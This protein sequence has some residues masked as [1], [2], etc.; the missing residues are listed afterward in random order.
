MGMAVLAVLLTCLTFTACSDDDDD[1]IVVDYTKDIVGAWV[2]EEGEKFEVLVVKADGTLFS[3][4]M[5]DGEPWNNVKGTWTLEGKHITMIFEDDDNFDGTIEVIAGETL[6][7]I[8]GVSG[9]RTIYHYTDTLLP[10]QFVG[11]WTCLQ[12]NHAEALTIKSDGSIVSTGMN[13]GNYWEEAKGHINVANGFYSLAFTDTDVISAGRYEIV[14]G[15]AMV[16]HDAVNDQTLTYEYCEKDLSK[17]IVGQWV[18]LTSASET[19]GL[20]M[21]IMT[22]NEDGTT[23]YTGYDPVSS[24]SGLNGLAS[25]K[26]FGDLMVHI[27]P[28][29]YV[30]YGMPK[31][32]FMRMSYSEDGMDFGD[33]MTLSYSLLSGDKV[34]ES[35][36]SWLRVKQTL[37]L[38]EMKY[39]YKTIYLSNVKGLD[40]DIELMGQTFNFAKMDGEAL[41]SVLS[42]VDYSVEFPSANTIKYSFNVQNSPVVMECPI[43]VDGNKMTIKMSSLVPVMRDID[44][45]TFQDK[46]DTQLH[47]YMS[48]KCFIDFFGNLSLMLMAQKGEINIEDAA[49][50]EAW[51]QGVEDVVESINLSF[52]MTKSK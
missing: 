41:H 51:F 40:E 39:D 17:E 26:M 45:Y 36:I 7:L 24:M 52:V 6:A 12:P 32:T 31:Y 2:A 1:T 10:A 21:M 44:V 46:Y 34:I 50:V 13:D 22:F 33:T 16:F 37:N 20:N 8:D 38:P 49:A 29:E 5:E 15:M 43:K 3:D 19:A 9:E 18:N 23:I 14:G 35:S 4:G 25:Y 27:I 28:D 11:T 48:T 47:M 42:R 30:Q